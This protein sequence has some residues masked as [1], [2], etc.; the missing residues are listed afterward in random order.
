M[1]WILKIK[2]WQLYLLLIFPNL[3]NFSAFYS[4]LMACFT[5]VL[6]CLWGF[7]IIY[8]S[9]LAN[10]NF[11]IKSYIFSILIIGGIFIWIMFFTTYD[12]FL[13]KDKSTNIGLVLF[14]IFFTVSSFI[15]LIMQISKT[16]VSLELNKPNLK[17]DDWLST[18]FQLFFLIFGIWAI[19]SRVN[20]IFLK[21]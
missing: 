17:M 20:K 19:Q 10:K 18:F 16:I 7:S 1:K 15:N 13:H 11:K 21:I 9:R 14:F 4:N 5:S 8:F 12:T 3:F 6:F 2:N